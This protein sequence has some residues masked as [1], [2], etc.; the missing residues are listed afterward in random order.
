MDDGPGGAIS[1]SIEERKL[2]IE[3]VDH[4][5]LT[6]GLEAGL[7]RA[8]C[9]LRKWIFRFSDLG[10]SKGLT[11]LLQEKLFY[12][13]VFRQSDRT[14]VGVPGLTSF[15]KALQEVSA[16]GP[17]RL[18]MHHRFQVDRVQNGESRFRT[19][20]FGDS[21]GIAGSSAERRSDPKQLLIE[22]HNRRPLGPAAARA[23]RMYR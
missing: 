19:I 4:A 20:R 7:R 18:I 22:L 9:D 2:R 21:G 23:L 13:G 1:T 12:G 14:V 3:A 5:G 15:P 16:N 6:P 8:C 17:V 11:P 10:Q